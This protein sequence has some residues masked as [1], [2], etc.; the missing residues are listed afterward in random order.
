MKLLTRHLHR[1]AWLLTRQ[2]VTAFGTRKDLLLLSEFPKSGGTWLAQMLSAA[3]DLPFPQQSTLPVLRNAIIHN[4]WSRSKNFK[5]AVYLY[6]DGRDVYT[7]YFFHRLRHYSDPQSPHYFATRRRYEPVFGHYSN[8]TPQPVLFRAFLS[9][10]ISN[11]GHGARQNWTDHLRSWGVGSTTPG[12]IYVSYE[13]LLSEPGRTLARVVESIS[14]GQ[15]SQRELAA[16]VDKYSMSAQTGRSPGQEDRSSHI[17]KG[18]VGDWKNYFN[19]E[20][21]RLFESSE[22]EGLRLGDYETDS[23]WVDL[24]PASID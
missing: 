14:Q 18:V 22:G 19:Q 2:Y 15:E 11:P 24:A 12:I 4:H 13:E 17:R 8:E 9:F 20:S 5:H 6:R 3:L 7:S 1:I 23:T 10:E 21:A 16:I